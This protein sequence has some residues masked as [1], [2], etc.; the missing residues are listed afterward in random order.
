MVAAILTIFMN[1]LDH[2]LD[3]HVAKIR[4]QLSRRCAEM[5]DAIHAKLVPF[6]VEFHEPQGGYFIWLKLPPWVDPVRLQETAIT[7]GV[8]FIR[9]DRCAAGN[10]KDC[11]MSFIRLS[12]AFY[13]VEELLFAIDRLSEAMHIESS[14]K[15]T[16]SS[17][18]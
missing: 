12:F 17:A 18:R 8:N 2:G 7:H 13:E 10:H 5:C 3:P 1:D 15:R 16:T 11:H 6:G 14:S 4:Q 9:G